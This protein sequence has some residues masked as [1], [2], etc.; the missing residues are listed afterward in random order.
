MIV[1]GVCACVRA[2]VRVSFQVDRYTSVAI[3]LF[4]HPC[5]HLFIYLYIIYPFTY[6]SDSDIYISAS[7]I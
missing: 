3:D 5:L 4:I 2:C 6:I 1:I 7:D